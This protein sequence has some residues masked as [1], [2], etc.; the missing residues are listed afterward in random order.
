[1]KLY[2][3]GRDD[4]LSGDKLS[5]ESVKE[6]AAELLDLARKE[7]IKG[8]TSKNEMGTMLYDAGFEDGKD[9]ALKDLPRW[10]VWENGA[11]GNADNIPIALVKQYGGYKLASCLGVGGEKYIMLSDLAKLPG[12]KED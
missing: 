6:S 10:R 11:G 12:F 5:N 7:L 2:N 8:G 3:E 1:M 4:G 9:E